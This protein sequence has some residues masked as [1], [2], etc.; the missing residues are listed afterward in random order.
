M[1]KDSEG[2]EPTPTP[3]PKP[4]RPWKFSVPSPTRYPT[5]WWSLVALAVYFISFYVVGYRTTGIVLNILLTGISI[6][7][8]VS[9]GPAA[10]DAFKNGMQS[11]VDKIIIV[12]WGAWTV[13]IFQRS[14]ALLSYVLER[15]EWLINGPI[16][17]LIGVLILILGVFA[18]YSTVSDAQT[19]T[20]ERRHI[21]AATFGGGIFVGGA[22]VYGFLTQF[23]FG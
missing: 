1:S 21:L 16:S 14:Y 4:K 5:V 2:V 17:G 13:L 11:A 23:N 19:P 7:M 3:K 20:S 6:V 8:S 22:I 10:L 9:W 18:A 15:P 12:V